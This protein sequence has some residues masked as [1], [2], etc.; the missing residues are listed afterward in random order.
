LL[1]GSESY[2]TVDLVPEPLEVG[3]A[4]HADLQFPFPD[5]VQCPSQ[6]G[7]IRLGATGRIP[8]DLRAAGGV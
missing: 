7:P 1:C 5:V 6:P 8:E 2:I 3:F 4:G